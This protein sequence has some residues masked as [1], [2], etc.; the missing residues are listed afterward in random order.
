MSETPS[1]PEVKSGITTTEFW[2]SLAA[3]VAGA[4]AGSGLI[5]AESKAGQIVGL[6]VAVLGAIGYT[7]ARTQAKK[8]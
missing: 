8:Q 2:L 4:I 5:A 7:F 3:V 6:I 1:A